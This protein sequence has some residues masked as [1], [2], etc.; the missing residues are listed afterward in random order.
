MAALQ[1]TLV[2][3][4]ATPLCVC[5]RACARLYVCVFA[6]AVL[7]VSLFCYSRNLCPTSKVFVHFFLTFSL[8][9]SVLGVLQPGLRGGPRRRLAGAE[10]TR[11]G[12]PGEALA[13]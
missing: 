13:G 10:E 5:V 6:C 3:S 1:T 12:S 7:R 4:A 9:R 8:T 2:C 11:R